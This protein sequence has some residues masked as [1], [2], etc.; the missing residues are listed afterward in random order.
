M[1]NPLQKCC[2]SLSMSYAGHGG[3]SDKNNFFLKCPKRRHDQQTNVGDVSRTKMAENADR[4]NRPGIASKEEVEDAI[5]AL[6]QADWVKLMRFE[7]ILLQRIRFQAWGVGN[8]DL[9]QEAVVSFLEAG[10]RYWNRD[11][12]TLLSCLMGAMRSIASNWRQSGK[13]NLPPLLTSDLSWADAENAESPTVV[14]VVPDQRPDPEQSVLLQEALSVIEELFQ[15]DL[16][17]S[18][19]IEC[20]KDRLTGPEIKDSL[21]LTQKQL[22]TIMRRI[23]RQ[24]DGHWPKGKRYVQ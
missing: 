21:G 2:I 19:V 16:E 22:E 1:D 18:L 12:F 4:Q 17:A 13:K 15:D 6:T 10:R 8:G 24:S 5:R 20:L 3:N 9:I 14:T 23:R 11:R 7:E